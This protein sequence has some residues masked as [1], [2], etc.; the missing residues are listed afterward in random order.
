MAAIPQSTPQL[1]FVKADHDNQTMP[2]EP[3]SNEMLIN[4]E[5]AKFCLKAYSKERELIREI[6][7]KK[8]APIYV[9]RAIG[10][11]IDLVDISISRRHCV[12]HYKDLMVDAN[13]RASTGFCIYDLKSTHGTF[14]NGE[15]IPPMQNI[16][17]RPGD[18]VRFGL[19]EAEFEFH[20]IE[21]TEA[22][23][24]MVDSTTEQQV[25]N[26]EAVQPE[27]IEPPVEDRVTEQAKFLDTESERLNNFLDNLENCNTE[28]L[29]FCKKSVTTLIKHLTQ[30]S[31]NGSLEKEPDTTADEDSPVQ[32]KRNRKKQTDDLNET[33]TEAAT[34]SPGRRGRKKRVG[35]EA[36]VNGD[37]AVNDPLEESQHLVAELV[38]GQ[39]EVNGEPVVE[40]KRGR[41]SK[42][43]R[44]PSF[45]NVLNQITPQV[46]DF[47]S[48]PLL[49]Q[50][51]QSRSQTN[52]SLSNCNDSVAESA[53]ETALL[54][55][56]LKENEPILPQ[57]KKRGRAKKNSDN[58]LTPVNT[59]S[60]PVVKT[61]G[62]R[63]RKKNNAI[64]AEIDEDAVL[65]SVAPRRG[66]ARDKLNVTAPA[67]LE[68][69]PISPVMTPEPSTKKRGRKR[70][71]A[72][73]PIEEQP[74]SAKKHRRSKNKDLDDS[75]PEEIATKEAIRSNVF[76]IIVLRRVVLPPRTPEPAEE[77]APPPLLSIEPTTP[78]IEQPVEDPLLPSDE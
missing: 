72:M 2:I 45:V 47:D 12:F 63:G 67:A 21:T 33:T 74:K 29:D 16:T 17:L 30:L 54:P 36:L 75:T 59:I 62:K 44:N 48:D 1:R 73:Q 37:T 52:A 35:Q 11:Q 24:P 51:V 6:L 10:C 70:K 9:G 66:R 18:I 42:V 77:S 39:P 20:E 25:N 53:E 65:S 26:T 19:H 46:D 5:P 28:H 60:S 56:E 15:K 43:H 69:R 13:Q 32:K 4:V 41:K 38:N 61:P 3:V 40:R 22:A 14:L 34:K 50:E 57:V 55:T 78:I 31:R 27:R 23:N 7:L 68:V 49:L 71:T 8:Y 76:P 58:P 64:V